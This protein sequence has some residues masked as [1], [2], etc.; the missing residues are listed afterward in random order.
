MTGS[1]P[2]PLKNLEPWQNPSERPYVVVKNITKT[3]DDG[4]VAVNDVSFSIYKG[5]LFSLLGRSG[6]GKTTLLRMLAG[7]ETPTSGRIFIDGADM[8]DTPPHKR[9]VSMVF[10]SYALFPHMTVEQNVAFGLKQEGLP[11]DEIKSRVY[12]YLDLVQMVAHAKRKPSQLSGGEKQRVALARSLV[13]HPKVVLLDE[14]MAALDKKLRESTQLELVNIQDKVGVTFVMVSHD[15]EEAMTMST[16]ISLMHEGRIVQT[17]TPTEIYEYPNS[18]YVANFIGTVNI[19]DGMVVESESDHV[20]IQSEGLGNSLY[21][22]Y[23]ASAPL[24]SNVHVAI[25]PEKVRI[26]KELTRSSSDYNWTRGI[27]QDI[28]YLGDVSIY[29]V[30]LQSGKMALSTVTNSVRVA[31]RQIQWDDEVFLSWNPENGIVLTM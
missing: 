31:E 28:V 15:Q 17:G 29:Y 13:K 26:S 23:S 10:Q 3:F 11:K 4:R 16:R 21:I 1:I 2:R 8:T 30:K 27:V 22:G 7:F 14:P 25:R 6:C 9:P 5:E 18:K 24:G 12:K 19:F 20:I